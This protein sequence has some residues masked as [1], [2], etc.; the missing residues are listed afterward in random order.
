MDLFARRGLYGARIE[1]IT[2]QADLGKGAFYNYFDSKEGLAAELLGAAVD[3]LD[4]E[5]LAEAVAGKRGTDRVAALLRAHDRFFDEQPQFLLLFHQ[6]RGLLRVEA[7]ARGSLGGA[8][9]HYLGRLAGRLT[10]R[11]VPDPGDLEAAALVAGALAGYR[12]FRLSAGLGSERLP[13]DRALASGVARLLGG[14]GPA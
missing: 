13:L 9:E 11:E 10:G 2:E 5:Y 6:A 12:S 8:V 7:G 3:R 4:R 14:E 1:D